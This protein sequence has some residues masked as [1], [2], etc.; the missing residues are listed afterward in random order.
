[1]ILGRNTSLA[2]ILSAV[3]LNHEVY[4]YCAAEDGKIPLIS[5]DV[6]VVLLN[7]INASQLVE[8]YRDEKVKIYKK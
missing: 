6:N 7:K 5:E 4:V 3:D 8:K 1:M 2:Y